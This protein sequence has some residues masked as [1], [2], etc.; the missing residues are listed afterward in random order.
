MPGARKTRKG[1]TK[2][3]PNPEVRGSASGPGSKGPD[4]YDGRANTAA[5][6]KLQP[7][8]PTRATGIVVNVNG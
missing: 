3:N 2:V 6:T 5:G 1:M 8:I 7:E 4:N